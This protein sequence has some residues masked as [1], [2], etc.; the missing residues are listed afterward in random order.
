MRRHHLGHVDA[1]LGVGVAVVAVL[2]SVWLVAAVISSPN[3][4]FTSL[5]AAVARSDILHSIDQILPQ[6]PSIFSDLQTFLNNQGFPQ[7]FSTLTPPSTPSVSTPTERADARAGRPRRLLDGQDPRH[8]LQ[9]RAGGIGLRGRARVSWP[10]TRTWWPGRAPATP[11]CSSGNNAYDAT[12][13]FFDPSF[14]L[15]VLRTDAPLGPALT[16]SPNL[17]ARGTQAA[18]LGY[19]E[20]GA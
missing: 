2:F 1:V 18:I 3:S 4:R 14:D 7:V 12:T 13:V 10:P 15:A 5:D 19:P 11:R 20:D 9:Q 16:I 8:G 6:A 17:V